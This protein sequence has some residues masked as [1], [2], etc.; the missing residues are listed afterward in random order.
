MRTRAGASGVGAAGRAATVAVAPE[1]LDAGGVTGS[2]ETGTTRGVGSMQFPARRLG[3]VLSIGARAWWVP[4]VQPPPDVQAMSG[5]QHA[6]GTQQ[7][8]FDPPAVAGSGR[9]AAR[10]RAVTAKATTR[11]TNERVMRE[12]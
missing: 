7:A 8:I 1:A 4:V 2:N 6:L 12:V 10:I 3:R 11:R 9:C 5:W